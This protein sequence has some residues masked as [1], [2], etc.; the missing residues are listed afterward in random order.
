MERFKVVPRIY[1]GVTSPGSDLCRYG[2]GESTQ[3]GIKIEKRF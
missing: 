3:L 2:V 1:G